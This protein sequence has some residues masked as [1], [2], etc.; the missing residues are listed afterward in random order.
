M[1]D[2]DL[3]CRPHTFEAIAAN[4]G[5]SLYGYQTDHPP[6]AL[7]SPDYFRPVADRLRAADFIRATCL[8]GDGLYVA[9]LLVVEAS[10]EAVR[11]ASVQAL[12]PVQAGG[13]TFVTT[14]PAVQAK[15]K[16]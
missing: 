3:R 16:A 15:P 13:L 10:R 2:L 1:P 4:T 11:T 6:E 8:R 5:S 14:A 9:D 12:R 7:A